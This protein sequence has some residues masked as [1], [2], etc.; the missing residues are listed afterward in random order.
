LY[1]TLQIV[2]YQSISHAKLSWLWKFLQ[3]ILRYAC[4][5]YF[6]ILYI[7]YLNSLQLLLL[8]LLS[9]NCHCLFL[10]FFKM[11][12]HILHRHFE[13]AIR[14]LWNFT[15]NFMQ[16]NIAFFGVFNNFSLTEL[17]VIFFNWK[18]FNIV[19]NNLILTTTPC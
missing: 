11:S 10:F 1:S 15:Q 3:E 12:F 17:N 2:L 7:K 5:C 14:L 13:K 18:R 6:W 4:R 19:L 16:K 9:E 8:P